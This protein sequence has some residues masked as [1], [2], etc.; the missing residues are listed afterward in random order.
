[1]FGNM[2]PKI[3]NLL[4]F[5]NTWTKDQSISNTQPAASGITRLSPYLTLRG[6]GWATTNSSSQ[7]VAFRQFVTPV[8]GSSNPTGRWKLQYSINNATFTDALDWNN[9]STGSKPLFTVTGYG[10]F[11]TD[12][13]SLV[14]TLLSLD[15][16]STGSSNHI[17]MTFSGTTRAAWSSDSTGN[18][19]FK[20]AG[21]NP[22]HNIYIGSSIGSQTQI[23][24][25]YSGGIYNYGGVFNTGKVTAG[26]SD[27]NANSTLTTFGSLAVRGNLVTSTSYTMGENETFVYVDPSQT[28]VCV[29]TPV[30]CNT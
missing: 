22:T 3:K 10:K 17:G 21:T 27:T 16:A 2:N 9:S 13:S 11:S 30:A 24:Q 23:L 15:V 20:V 18:S 28:N 25:I 19:T 4:N 14:D 12:N 6:N 29:G 26:Q 1:M 5:A 8:Q 7:S